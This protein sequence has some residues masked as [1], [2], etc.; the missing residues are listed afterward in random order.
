MASISEDLQKILS[1]IEIS[2]EEVENAI[3]KHKEIREK[4]SEEIN[5]KSLLTGSYKRKTGVKP[6]NDVDIFLWLSKE[7]A[8]IEYINKIDGI[9]PTSL[10]EKLKRKI[11]NLDIDH[12]IIKVQDHSLGIKYEKEEFGIDLI[13]AFSAK[14]PS[15]GTDFN[16]KFWIPEKETLEWIPAFPEKHRVL[17]I[18][19]NKKANSKVVPLVKLLKAWKNKQSEKTFKSFHLEALCIYL[20]SINLDIFKKGKNMFTVLTESTKEIIRILEDKLDIAPELGLAKDPQSYFEDDLGRKERS[21]RKLKSLNRQLHEIASLEDHN[22]HQQAS[23]LL[24]TIFS[25]KEEPKK[26]ET[27]VSPEAGKERFGSA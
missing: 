17:L 8:G 11:K 16:R 20:T 14:D 21:I 10:L 3:S 2:D 23:K 19:A 24:H 25:G 6:L 9:N 12:D 22:K 26:R 1:D 13:P 4:I 7:F 15:E 18:N 27:R 5:S